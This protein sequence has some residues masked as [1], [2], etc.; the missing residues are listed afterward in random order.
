VRDVNVQ[1]RGQVTLF[2]ILGIA[3][4]L[5]I[6]LIIVFREEL[7]I[8]LP[9][10]IVPTKTASIQRFIETCSEQVAQEALLLLGAQG[11]YIYLP[12]S[13]ENN[14]LAHFNTGLK[15]PLWHYQQ[16][17]RIPTIQ[18]MQSHLSRYMNENL[19]TCL[20]DLEDFQNQ[21]DIIEKSPVQT[22]TTITNKLVSFSITYPIDIINKEGTKITEINK[23]QTDSPIKLKHA[24]EVAKAIMEAES[25]EMRVEKIAVDLIAL[26]PDIPL[27]GF[28]LGCTQKIWSK[29]QVEK[30][31]KTLLTTNLPSI[32]PDFTNYIPVPDNQPYI[33]NHYVWRVT[34]LE[35]KD[36]RAGFTLSSA[37]PFQ[38]N[39]RPSGS[40]LLKSSELRG[41]QLASFLCTQQW[42]FVYD[43]RF[44]VSV[45]VED[46]DNNFNLN[47][48]FIAQVKNNRGSREQ[49]TQQLA[50]TQPVEATEEAYCDNTYG[51]YSMRINT[52]DN[53]SDP[54]LTE[55]HEPINDVNISFTCLKYTCDLGATSYRLGGSIARLDAL[56][57]YC[58]NGVLRGKK[59][60][61]K[62]AEQF[63]T[64]T[65][66]GEHSLYLTPIKTIETYNVV[67]HSGSSILPLAEDEKA[68]ISITYKKDETT[69]H[70]TWGGYPQESDVPLQ[71]IELLA[72]ADIPYKLEI[73]LV[74]TDGN[75]RGAF[76]GTWTPDWTALKQ[77]NAVT[78]RVL[79]HKPSSDKA[80]LEFLSKLEE[81]S[82]AI[83]PTIR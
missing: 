54:R 80:I 17:N 12:P 81:E 13:I 66:G 34:D 55:T 3:L 30:K 45:I 43:L 33:Q 53:V 27:S 58:V 26:D 79:S 20:N 44:P 41:Q 29:P 10:Q 15:V 8:F 77:A 68:F 69:I 25:R 50:F 21:Y 61:H 83:Q 60:E 11:G 36:I 14:P 63:V 56:F 71:P 59:S 16:Q 35:Y 42:K 1:K 64:T 28:E 37:Q 57:P 52:F 82:T 51:D 67:K 62:T 2:I 6:T 47:F 65:S 75:L 73:H 39:V 18:L 31:L 72:G 4:I 38:F 40:Q 74:D 24:Y 23:F 9:E 49:L 78:F 19:K 70:E 46:I 22:E 5:A 32:R 7:T 76:S 48:G